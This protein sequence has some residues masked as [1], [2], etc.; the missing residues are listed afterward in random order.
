MHR[1]LHLH[2]TNRADYSDDAEGLLPKLCHTKKRLQL[3]FASY[4]R[5]VMQK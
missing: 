3:L 4:R 2:Y 1:G 5:P